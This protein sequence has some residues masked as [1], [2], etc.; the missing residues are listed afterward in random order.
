[1]HTSLAITA[2][3]YLKGNNLNGDQGRIGDWLNVLT[4]LSG[5]LN[6]TMHY[7]QN[8]SRLSKKA[9]LDTLKN[10]QKKLKSMVARKSGMHARMK[11]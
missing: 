11:C 7:I 4:E 9:L 3:I 1:M 2:G 10:N 5:E 6:L 8:D